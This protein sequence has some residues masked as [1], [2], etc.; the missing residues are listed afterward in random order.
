MSE[1]PRRIRLDLVTDAERLIY[2]AT[3]AIEAMRADVRLT[4]A[5]TLLYEARMLVA[6]VVDE[7]LAK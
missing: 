1:I 7:D 3:S 6:D 5:Q 4:K 2:E